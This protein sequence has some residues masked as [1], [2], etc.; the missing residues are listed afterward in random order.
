MNTS[1]VQADMDDILS[2][3]RSGV[4]EEGSKVGSGSSDL[5]DAAAAENEAEDDV[6][7]LSETDMVEGSGAASEVEELIDLDAF[8]ASGESKTV[9]S[10]DMS[11]V[12]DEL[13]QSEV[14]AP[15]PAVPVAP[16]G[17][18]ADEFDRL[19][20]EISQEQ[21]QQVV[22]SKISKEDLMAEESPLGVEEVAQADPVDDT[23]G[24]DEE[25]IADEPEA[26]SVVAENLDVAQVASAA[27]A[28]FEV[29]AIQG[30]EGMQVAFPAEVLAMA[31]RP[32]V[33][34]WLA[35]N[36]PEVVERLVK[37]EISKLAQS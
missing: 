6:L 22:A 31:L 13:L 37:E 20:A 4:A 16:L 9:A 2:S 5:I 1:P 11:N 34:D 18:A 29:G 25:V 7:E 24:A 28:R 17:D 3:I 26:A 10:N 32:M 23:L 35:K 12:V 15:A 36:L 27:A 30:P 33:Q 19:L 21:Q 14:G 8:G